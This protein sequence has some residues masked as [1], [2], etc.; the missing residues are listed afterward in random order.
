[1]TFFLCSALPGLAP[2]LR[3][4]ATKAGTRIGLESVCAAE[5]KLHNLKANSFSQ[6]DNLTSVY[7]DAAQLDYGLG[8]TGAVRFDDSG[9]RVTGTY[10]VLG[11]R[12]RGGGGMRRAAQPP[13]PGG[14]VRVR[15]VLVDADAERGRVDGRARRLASRHGGP[16]RREG[17]LERWAARL[18]GSSLQIGLRKPHSRPCTATGAARPGFRP[19]TLRPSWCLVAGLNL[20]EQRALLLAQMLIHG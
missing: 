14:A 18:W 4:R 8:E 9:D 16:H 11:R 2:K 12:R 19:L 17:Q 1:M 10:R 3:T 7:C 20:H 15:H 13:R 5:K 6:C